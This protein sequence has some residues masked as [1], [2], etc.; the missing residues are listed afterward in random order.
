MQEMLSAFDRPG[1][2]GGSFENR[3]RLYLTCVREVKKAVPQGFHV[4]TR[5]G[6]SDMVEK[7]CGFGTTEQNEIDL[8]ETKRLISLLYN[9]GI[10]LI[11]V[12][13][14][15]PYF[16]PHVNR[17]FRAGAY[18]PPEKPEVGLQRFWDTTK[19]L[20]TW[21]PDILFIG[22]G[23]SFYRDNLMEKSESMLEEGVCDFVGYGRVNLAY[24]MLYR[25]YLNGNFDP[26]KCC[27]SCSRCTVL[28]R[29]KCVSGC[30]M[31]NPY[32]KNL[33]NEK[34]K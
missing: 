28:M 12:T 7:P 27:V 22:S 20:K 1:R 10:R 6:A 30:A 21:F 2:Y 3:T 25:D 31:F 23:L 17:P 11:N 4:V 33:F 19:Q 9:E 32:Y 29:K 8:T 5:L 26:K 34:C 24:P 13:I 15:N 14:G 18:T 16:N